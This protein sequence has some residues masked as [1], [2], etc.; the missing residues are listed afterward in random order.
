MT[1]VCQALN[2]V[3]IS[4]FRQYWYVTFSDARVSATYSLLVTA[5][6]V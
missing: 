2:F 6:V 4:Y 3:K 1:T 5:S